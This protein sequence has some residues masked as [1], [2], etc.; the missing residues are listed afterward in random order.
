MNTSYSQTAV[1]ALLVLLATSACGKSDA[2]DMNDAS[3]D[4]PDSSGAPGDAVG[5]DTNEEADAGGN[6]AAAV[7]GPPFAAANSLPESDPGHAG[8]QLFL[9]E[10]WGVGILSSLPPADFVAAL[11]ETQPEIFG[12]QFERFGFIPD[13]S[14]EFPIGL[15]RDPAH[16]ETVHETCGLCHVASLPDGRL[17]IGAPNEQLQW[18]AFRLAVEEA[19]MAEGNERLYDDLDREKLGLLGPGRTNAESSSYPR[20]VPADFPAYW[21]L[22]LRNDLNYMGTGQNVKTEAYFALYTFGCGNPNEE[23]AVVPFPGAEKLATFIEF[24]GGIT[25]PDAPTQNV[26][27]VARGESVFAEARCNSCH[28]VDDPEA[29]FVVPLDR[30]EGAVERIPGDDPDW[31]RGSIRTSAAHRILQD[32]D[33]EGSGGGSDRGFDDL[34]AFI[35]SQGLS[36]RQTSGY[37]TNSLRGVWATAPF[38]HNGS[39]PTLEDLLEP[40]S[41]RPVT[42]LQGDFEVDTRRFGFSNEGHEFGVELSDEDKTALL[43]YLRSL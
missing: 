14:N 38:L 13:P 33:A 27:L 32:G 30:T 41:E 23:T 37:R 22:G 29:E 25:A 9:Y 5:G 10:T 26:T 1:S 42:F 4:S 35:I 40:A 17:W 21:D 6:D 7:P 36:V 24:L 18:G 12:N 31:E 8:E 39:V 28:I 3:S 20:L 11:P 19:W 16:P 43:A 2:A 34:I 15:Q